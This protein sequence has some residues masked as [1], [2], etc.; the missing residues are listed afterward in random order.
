MA[1][2]N[3]QFVKYYMLLRNPLKRAFLLDAVFLLFHEK[4]LLL[5][6]LEGQRRGNSD[7]I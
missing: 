5:K 3:V 1:K 4:N 6:V 2:Y 7:G